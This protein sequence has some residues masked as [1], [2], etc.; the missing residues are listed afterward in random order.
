MYEGNN[1]SDNGSG[2]PILP[3]PVTFIG[4]R[5]VTQNESSP[6]PGGASYL[7]ESAAQNKLLSWSPDAF[8]HMALKSPNGF[9]LTP[10]VS[11]PAISVSPDAFQSNGESKNM[12]QL[13]DDS[14][15][16]VPAAAPFPSRSKNLDAKFGCTG[17][18]PHLAPAMASHKHARVTRPVEGILMGYIESFPSFS[19]S[20]SPG[21]PSIAPASAII[22]PVSAPN[23]LLM[24]PAPSLQL[25]AAGLLVSPDQ[26]STETSDQ[27]SLF[28]YTPLRRASDSALLL[29]WLNLSF[30]QSAKYSNGRS[31]AAH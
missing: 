21:S 24:I 16:H 1:A 11:A 18:A 14:A 27:N 5:L 8:L 17:S 20:N 7:A 23:P 9:V 13:K 26:D 3:T 12:V 25:S 22:S 30:L 15:R 31:L 29:L 19:P 6:L 2:L 10:P 28:T 4:G